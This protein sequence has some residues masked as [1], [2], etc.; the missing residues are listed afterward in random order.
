MYWKKETAY[1]WYLA[2]VEQQAMIIEAFEEIENDLNAVEEMQIYLLKQKQT[3]RWR[4]GKATA[5]ACYALLMRGDDLISASNKMSA[6]VGKEQFEFPVEGSSEAGTSYTKMNWSGSEI[7]PEMKDVSF[8]NEGSSIAWGALYFQYFQ[9]SDAVEEAN[10]GLSISRD[11][12]VKR[13]NNEG[14]YLK[15]IDQSVH[16]ETGEVVVVKLTVKS[17]RDLEFVHLKDMKAAGLEPFDPNSGYRYS[18]GEGPSSEKSPGSYP[19]LSRGPCALGPSNRSFS[20][21]P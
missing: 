17:D 10:T 16:L 18:D 13:Y 1:A 5:E 8:K 12:Y 3:H 19:H 2:D 15:L 6:S 21:E 4:T 11:L 20:L 7:K 14:P 9:S